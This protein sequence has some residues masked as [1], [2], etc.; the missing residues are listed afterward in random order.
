MVKSKHIILLEELETNG[1]NQP[2]N[3]STF[4]KKNFQKPKMVR[5]LTWSIEGDSSL[6][7]LKDMLFLEY[8]LFDYDELKKTIRPSNDVD[9]WENM[10]WFDNTDFEIRPRLK[11]IEF[12]QQYRIMNSSFKLNEA[13]IKNIEVQKMLTW[14]AVI[15]SILNLLLSYQNYEMNKDEHNTSIKQKNILITTP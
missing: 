6:L 15:I 2:Y 7:F 8:V 13:N 1:F 5:P 11:G 14:L 12:L 3:V 4:M 10:K 9:N